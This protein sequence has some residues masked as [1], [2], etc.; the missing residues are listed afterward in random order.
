[1][2]SLWRG[3]KRLAHDFARKGDWLLLTLC[4]IS[5]IYGM[6]LIYSAGHPYDTGVSMVT[7]QAGAMLAG[8]LLYAVVSFIDT[9]VYRAA[10]KWLALFN[11]LFIA[12]L[13]VIGKDPGTGNRSWLMLSFLPFNIQPAEIVKLTFIILLALHFAA[14]GDKINRP[15]SVLSLLLHAGFML[16]LIV[17]SSDDMGM[18]VVYFVIFAVM[19][20]CSR[21][22]WAWLLG[23]LAATAGTLPLL[24]HFVLRPYQKDRILTILDPSLDPTGIGWQAAQSKIALQNGGLTGMG[25]LQ[26]TQTQGK[27]LPFS[28]TDF[29]FSVG[30]EEL[31]LIGC[32]CIVALLLFIIVRCVAVSL[33]ARNTTGRL[34]CVGV[35]AMLSFQLIENVGMCLGLL[36]VIGLTLPFF[37]YGGTS[38]LTMMVAAGLVSAVRMHPG[39]ARNRRA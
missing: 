32:L 24:W 30:G 7:V 5:S 23:G 22:N 9:D 25:L 12:S 31:G 8:V 13:F 34:I 2:A 19:C 18:A 29:I 3:L 20:V 33:R 39:Q 35:A 17:A 15:L 37:S 1:M 38:M 6:V 27:R 4:V 26:G 16:G 10:W 28:Y 21:L 36:P 11:V 14:L